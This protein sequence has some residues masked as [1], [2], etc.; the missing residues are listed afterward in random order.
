MGRLEETKRVIEQ[1]GKENEVDFSENQENLK[2]LDRL[3]EA[4]MHQIERNS[5]ARDNNKFDLRLMLRCD[6]VSK[7]LIQGV[8]GCF[9]AM[10]IKSIELHYLDRAEEEA[11][12]SCDFCDLWSHCYAVIFPFYDSNGT[13]E[14][15]VIFFLRLFICT[16]FLTKAGLPTSTPG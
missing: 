5:D 12:V 9:Y 15:F 16:I 11:W 8:V 1:I 13:V 7:I 2:V 3:F 6:I 10:A 14:S 4:R